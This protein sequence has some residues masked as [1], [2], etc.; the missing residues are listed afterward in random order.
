VLSPASFRFVGVTELWSDSISLFHAALGGVTAPA[1]LLN[2]RPGADEDTDNGH[3]AGAEPTLL[4]HPNEAADSQLYECARRR[5]LVDAARLLPG[6]DW[7]RH[8]RTPPP[9]PTY[10]VDKSGH[11]PQLLPVVDIT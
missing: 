11:F 1:E 7:E 2:T 8:M 6:T 4:A 10:S 5:M 3:R 9:G